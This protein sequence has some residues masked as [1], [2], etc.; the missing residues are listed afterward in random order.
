MKKKILISVYA[1]EPNF[2][3]EGGVGWNVVKE[4]SAR[5]E[6]T[7]LTRANNK[8]SI[9]AS[10]EVWAKG[11]YWVYLDP[12]KWLTFWKKGA[13]G[14]QLYYILWQVQALSEA[15]KVLKFRDIDVVHHVTFGKYWIPSLLV[16]L[17]KPFVFGPVGGGDSTPKQL[18]DGYNF[19]GKLSEWMRDVIRFSLRLPTPIRRYYRNMGWVIAATEQTAV[20]LKEL[21]V[22]RIST[23]VQSGMHQEELDY[24]AGI[25]R[26]SSAESSPVRLVTACRLIH[27]KAVDLA[28]EAVA[29]VKKRGVAVELIVLQEGPEKANLIKLV[30]ELGLENEVRFPGRLGS[31]EEVYETISGADALIHPALHE[32]FGQSVLESLSLGVPVICLKWG[33]PG[34]IVDDSS[35]YRIEPG[36]REE[37]KKLFADAICK[38]TE[39]RARLNEITKA[40]RSR[41]QQFLWSNV[42]ESVEEAYERAIEHHQ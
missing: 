9:E 40:T 39:D 37:T 22:E 20:A 19:K 41:A 12:P 27:W 30:S 8:E 42:V 32:A 7:V 17:D 16:K 1:C 2:G 35:G 23:Q 33:G 10:E 11:V 14:L 34:V 31:L 4:L 36:N 26:I 24:Y 3:S 38:L 25:K 13:R 5:H 29:E 6:L 18:R 28:I 21:G 15:K